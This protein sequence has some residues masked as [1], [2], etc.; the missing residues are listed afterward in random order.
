VAKP[1]VT[2]GVCVKNGEYTIKDAIESIMRQDFPR[3]LMELIIVDGHSS[4][5]TLQVIR[6]C[7]KNTSTRAKFFCENEG[8]GWARQIVVDNASGEYI[9]WV[10][11]DM[12]LSRDFVKKQ[13][14]FMEQHPEIGIAK[15][16]MALEPASNMLATLE[17][18]SRAASKM[19]DYHSKKAYSKALGTS[20]SIY[21]TQSI[22]QVGGF[23]KD[24]RGYYEDLDVEIKVRAAGW[25]LDATDAKYLDYERLGLTWKNL[26]SRYWRRGY[27]THYFLHKNKGMLKHYRMFPPA[28]F[29]SGLVYA[30]RLFKL[31]RNKTVYLLPVQH[32]FKMTAF[33]LGFLR[34][35]LNSYEPK[36]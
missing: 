29:I 13:V 34:G 8:L 15:G 19:V 2:I 36:S 33:Y 9:V 28:A 6:N 3:E 12:I 22:M 23:D 21:R 11:G 25:L 18:F 17:A 4:D 30:R 26:W 16:K 20:G 7:L 14:E 5:K 1:V 10:D 24:M 31:T 35:H 27:Y 32:L